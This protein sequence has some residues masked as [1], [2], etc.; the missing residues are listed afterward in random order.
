ATVV[1]SPKLFREFGETLSAAVLFGSNILFW[2]KS[3]NYFD[4]P[5]DW[6]PLVHTWS[7]GVEEQFYIVFPLLLMVLWRLGARARMALIAVAA[8][9]SLALSIWGTANA[10][11]LT[12]YLL[13]TRAW[14]LLIGALVALHLMRVPA[15]EP[16]SQTPRWA[17]LLVGIAGLAM[18]FWSLLRYDRTIAFPGAAALLPCIGSAL[19]LWV[20][21]DTTNPVA[22][23]LSLAPLTFIGKISYSLYLWHWPLIVFADRYL[24][25]GALTWHARIGIVATAVFAAYASWRW[26]EQPFRARPGAGARSWSRAK[27]FL[28]A[29]GGTAALALM[30]VVVLAGEGWPK[31]FP[32]IESVSIERQKAMESQDSEWR[33]FDVK[34]C[35]MPN[36]SDWGGDACYLNR[37]PGAGSA[38]LWGDSFAWAYAYGFYHNDGLKLG[39]LQYTSPQCPPIL[40][41]HASSHPQCDAFDRDIGPVVRKYNVSTVIM[42]ANWTAYLRTRKIR[43]EDIAATVTTLRAR[44]LRVILIGQ[45]PVFPF[46]YPDEYF[47]KKYPQGEPVQ[48]QG[49]PVQDYY[50]PLNADPNLNARIL[51]AAH[52]DVFYDPLRS[53]CRVSECIFKQGDSYLV[54]DYG[55]WTHDGSVLAV[56]KLMEAANR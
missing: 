10:P 27:I 32:G 55:H 48:P 45:S 38:I 6:N 20:C 16:A 52:P 23:V 31:R 36:V 14:E 5:T 44:G 43:Y 19:L 11:T 37:H 39:V 35:F 50:A 28:A 3:A 1:V 24:S 8:I 51:E 53:L 29:G 30:G 25:Y 2:R 46:A 12:F 47:F 49:E 42:V 22:R 26:V 9:V 17:G 15:L 56:A 21:R 33:K 7:L 34:R 13:P 4:A 41:Y 40:G 18:I 54:E